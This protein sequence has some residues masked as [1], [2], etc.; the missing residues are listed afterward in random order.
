M[1]SVIEVKIATSKKLLFNFQLVQQRNI[2]MKPFNDMVAPTTKKRD[3]PVFV[4]L[5]QTT[6]K[7]TLSDSANA[8]WRTFLTI[9]GC[10]FPCGH[11]RLIMT[12]HNSLL[13]FFIFYA[14][15]HTRARQKKG[16][17]P[18]FGVMI[19]GCESQ[20]RSFFVCWLLGPPCPFSPHVASLW[21]YTQ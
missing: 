17:L 5:F 1:K 3:Q 8:A 6:Q 7:K 4:L 12:K 11:F 9:G 14:H 18:I 15:T 19:V 21:D 13:M 10:I 16:S 20:P 2:K